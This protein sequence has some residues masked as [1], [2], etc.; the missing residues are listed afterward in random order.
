MLHPD[1]DRSSKDDVARIVAAAIGI[2][3]EEIEAAILNKQEEPEVTPV[4]TDI[5]I[6]GTST[7]T[8]ITGMFPFK[9]VQCECLLL[10]FR[11]VCINF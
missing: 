10:R 11:I 8:T 4:D 9:F 7:S 5:A 3:V 1:D 2:P 6:H